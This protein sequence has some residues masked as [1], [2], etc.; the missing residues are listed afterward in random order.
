ME[1]HCSTHSHSSVTFPLQQAL[2]LTSSPHIL[3]WVQM[4]AETRC[5][6][7]WGSHSSKDRL[8]LPR[9]YASAT[10]PELG[11]APHK[12]QAGTPLPLLGGL[13]WVG[14][15]GLPW[16]ER[17]GTHHPPAPGPQRG[18]IHTVL[19]PLPVSCQSRTA[20]GP[21]PAFLRVPD[22]NAMS[23]KAGCAPAGVTDAR[24]DAAWG[25]GLAVMGSAGP[26]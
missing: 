6:S 12:R 23:P 8:S 15:W 25:G 4:Q 22:A 20:G 9:I 17:S 16:G 11:P 26:M 21:W 24:R 3:T 7:S 2:D 5:V 18:A 1:G 14:P 10:H 19:S 13:L